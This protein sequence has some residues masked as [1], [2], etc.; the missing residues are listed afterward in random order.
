MDPQ[1]VTEL[2]AF[3]QLCKEN[4]AVLHMPEMSFFKTWLQGSVLYI[5]ALIFVL[6]IVYREKHYII[7]WVFMPEFSAGV[8]P[9]YATLSNFTSSIQKGLT[10]PPTLAPKLPLPQPNHN[11]R[12][13]KFYG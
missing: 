11:M 2:K 5:S 9:I 8:L 3:V 13:A 1:K 4:S 10:P 12:V 7:K 6:F